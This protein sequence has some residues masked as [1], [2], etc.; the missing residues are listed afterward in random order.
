MYTLNNLRLKFI[1]ICLFESL[2]LCFKEERKRI[3]INK[4]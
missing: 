3:I 2:N 4:F 1:S